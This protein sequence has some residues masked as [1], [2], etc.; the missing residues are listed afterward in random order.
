MDKS[1]LY[2]KAIT[3]SLDELRI[4]GDWYVSMEVFG[5]DYKAAGEL[6]VREMSKLISDHE[7]AFS[8]LWDKLTIEWKR[9]HAF[10]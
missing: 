9:Q 5:L 2:S 7:S 8:A 3:G 6:T 10:A 1:E 4:Y